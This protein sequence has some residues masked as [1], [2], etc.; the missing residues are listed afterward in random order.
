[1]KL[2]HFVSSAHQGAEA[3]PAR[4][5]GTRSLPG[6][7]QQE[8]RPTITRDRRHGEA[9]ASGQGVQPQPPNRLAPQRERFGSG[10]AVRRGGAAAEQVPPGT[11]SRMGGEAP[12]AERSAAT[13]DGPVRSTGRARRDRGHGVQPGAAGQTE[14]ERSFRAVQPPPGVAALRAAGPRGRRSQ[15]L[16]AAGRE[17][18]SGLP[19][20][21]F[22][23]VRPRFAALAATPQ[24]CLGRWQHRDAPTGAMGYSEARPF[25]SGPMSQIRSENDCAHEG[26]HE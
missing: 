19:D 12:P 15:P 16:E 4:L 20:A 11:D 7:P 6:S 2:T 23:R 13:P 3:I 5:E 26:E 21:A 22:S 1:M 10:G 8:L 24:G 9:G 17:G 25:M 18:V 14:R